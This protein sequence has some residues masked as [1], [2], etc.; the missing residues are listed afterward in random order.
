MLDK[1]KAFFEDNLA[2][3][4]ATA[5]ANSAS[6]SLPVQLA[7]CALLLEMV[8]IDKQTA[9][10]EEQTLLK[11]MQQTFHIDSTQANK[12]VELAHDEL[13]QSTDYFQFTSLI[14]EYFS[15]AQKIEVIEAMWQ[16]AYSD[17]EIDAHER[18][19][20]RKI[21][22]LLHVPHGDHMAAKARGKEKAGAPE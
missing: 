1:I 5:S 2:P 17:H 7:S 19:L 6:G 15:Q 8:R 12:L 11:A 13:E 21:G 14:N 4:E 10:V 18:H 20:M 16:I 3:A 22:A 9:V